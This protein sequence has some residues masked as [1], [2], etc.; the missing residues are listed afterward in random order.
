MNPHISN[1][2]LLLNNRSQIN[3]YPKQ[4]GRSRR[5]SEEHS[6]AKKRSHRSKETPSPRRNSADKSSKQ[7][8]RNNQPL[9]DRKRDEK[10]E[11]KREDK[12]NTHDLRSRHRSPSGSIDSEVDRNGKVPIIADE[13]GTFENF[14]EITKKTVEGLRKRGINYLFPVQYES[15]NTIFNRKDLIVRDL[16]GSGKT[17]GFSLPMVEYLRKH[18]CFGTGKTQGIVLA[19]TRELAL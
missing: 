5:E 14:P 18:K 10:R 6:S 15:F 13:P 12:K 16:T 9:I 2:L 7:R 4:M 1:Y 19:P 11:E 8:I 3:Y 17:L